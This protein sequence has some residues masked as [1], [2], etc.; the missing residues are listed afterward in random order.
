[1]FNVK[2]VPLKSGGNQDSQAA[3]PKTPDSS[4]VEDNED[5]DCDYKFPEIELTLSE[6][7]DIV[8]T[9]SEDELQLSL[10]GI[11]INEDAYYLV[12]FEGRNTSTVVQATSRGEAITKARNKKVAGSKGKVVKARTATD[13]EVTAIRKGKWLRTR[14]SGSTNSNTGSYKFR[15]GLKKKAKGRDVGV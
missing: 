8:S 3:L 6:F 11:S 2:K 7:I 12:W 5:C 4:I 9:E 1:M 13:E 14:A 15:P 10:D